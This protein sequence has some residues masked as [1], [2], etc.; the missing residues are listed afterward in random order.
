MH[1]VLPRLDAIRTSFPPLRRRGVSTL[2][3]SD[4]GR[5]FEPEAE[6]ERAS[7]GVASMHERV[8]L[9]GG[10][11][12]IRSRRGEGTRVTAWLPAGEAAS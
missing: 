3:V 4:D 2:Q 1:A 9:Q 11:L 10:R 7:L 8:V 6:R 12:L 5:G